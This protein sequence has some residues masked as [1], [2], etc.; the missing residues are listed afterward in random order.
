MH[1][2]NISKGPGVMK[3]WQK[4]AIS[5]LVISQEARPEPISVY[6]VC[7]G[8]LISLKIHTFMKD[9]I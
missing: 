8:F 2:R 1:A 9:S 5:L 3:K 7:P 6:E 4:E